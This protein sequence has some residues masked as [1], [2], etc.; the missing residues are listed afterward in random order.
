MIVKSGGA[1]SDM[2]R[3]S[4]EGDAETDAFAKK[5]E[6]A[7]M[8]TESSGISELEIVKPE[9]LSA[10][11]GSPSCSLEAASHAVGEDGLE[12]MVDTGLIRETKIR[13]GPPRLR[14]QTGGN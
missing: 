13:T 11:E 6:E 14:R 1:R 10:M 8:T 7:C 9:T 4:V 2:L 12:A 3:S 5:A